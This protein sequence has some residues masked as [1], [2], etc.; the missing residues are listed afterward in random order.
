MTNQPTFSILLP[1]YKSAGI[2]GETIE[3]ILNQTIKD[4]ELIVV[5]DKSPDDTVRVVEG[6]QKKDPRIKL[7]RN[8]ENLGYSKNL[9][10]CRNLAIGEYIYLMGNDDILS[11]HALERTLE[12]FN[13]DKDVG[14]VVR[15]FFCFENKDMTK[16]VR[17]FGH[18]FDETKDRI[19][20]INESRELFLSVYCSIG[21]L[22]GLAMRREWVETPVHPDIF[23]AHAYPFFSVFRKHKVVHLKD[24]IVA[25]RIFSSQTRTLSTIYDPP[26]TLTWIWMFQRMLPGKKYEKA[27]NWGIDFIASDYVGLVQIKNYASTAKF[28]REVGVLVKYRPKNLI[29]PRFWVYFLVIAILPR[30]I[31]IPLADWYKRAIL[32]RNL[33]GIRLYN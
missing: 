28:F 25:V 7:F 33:R 21:Q 17:E 10:K 31:L 4:F 6:Y 27:R 9:E 14:A 26:P 5:D 12:A 16:P 32:S 2:I 30:S 24:Y 3:S 22:S 8:E 15:P 18:P 1:A 11:R 19:I 23:P 20:S 13:L 29:S